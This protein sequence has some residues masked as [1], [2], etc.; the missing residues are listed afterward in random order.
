MAITWRT[1]AGGNGGAISLAQSGSQMMLQGVDAL[2]KLAAEQQQLNIQNTRLITQKNTDD[3]LDQVAQVTSAADLSNPDTQQQLMQLRQGYG[4][5]IDRAA[6][7]DAIDNRVLNLQKQEI[8]ANQF[9]DAS[10]EREQRPLLEQLTEAGRAGDR[11]TVNK[12]LKENSF[13]NEADVARAADQ[14]LDAVTNRGYQAANQARA[15]RSEQRAIRSEQRQAEQFQMAR[16]D[17]QEARQLRRDSNLLNA[18][19]LEL[20]ASE[21]TLRAS[22]PLANTSTDVLADSTK[23]VGKVADDIE[24]W[25]SD[26]AEARNQLTNRFQALMKDGVNLG[27]D[28]GKVKIPPALLEQYLNQAKDNTYRSTGSL[29]SDLDD[30]IKTYAVSNPGAFRQ[31]AEVGQEIQKLREAS[32]LVNQGKI[33]VL[34][35]NKLDSSGLSDSI[36]TIRNR[37]PT[38]TR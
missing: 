9:A 21:A 31:A 18:A 11:T 25:F 1:V 10:L 26:N 24:P 15:E 3:Y 17:R 8:A 12:L 6:T 22:N 20:K 28:I 4:Q 30:W 36:Q 5:M 14:N 13:L 34:R 33:D 2:R 7:R 32:R 35:G 38:D 19:E 37:L 16:D 23:L 27:G 29:M